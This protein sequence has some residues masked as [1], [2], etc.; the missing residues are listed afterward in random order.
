MRHPA[1]RAREEPP[2]K[3]EETCT[4]RTP[5]PYFL[6]WITQPISRAQLPY[7]IERIAS[8]QNTEF[9]R[10]RDRSTT[11]KVSIPTVDH[12]GYIGRQR[13]PPL[14]N[15]PNNMFPENGLGGVRFVPA[16]TVRRF[17]R[18]VSH[19]ISLWH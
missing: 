7:A 18:K 9:Q 8:P 17:L 13:H 5:R 1:P 12:V 2:P 4:L 19:S 10:S 15:G 16:I 3:I 14:D 6:R 11:G